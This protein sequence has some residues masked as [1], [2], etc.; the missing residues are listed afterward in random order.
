MSPTGDSQQ[1]S[2]FRVG[3]CAERYILGESTDDSQFVSSVDRACDRKNREKVMKKIVGGIQNVH[4]GFY[5]HPVRRPFLDI[6][7]F[8]TVT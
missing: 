5:Y 1:C 8:A 6:F 7:N 2:S 3:I 4:P